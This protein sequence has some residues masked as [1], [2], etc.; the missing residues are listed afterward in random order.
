MVWSKAPE[1]VQ[2]ND[3]YAPY[4]QLDDMGKPPILAEVI[5]AE[6][7]LETSQRNLVVWAVS[8]EGLLMGNVPATYEDGK[9]KFTLGRKYASIYY[10]IQ[11]E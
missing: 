7:E 2:K 5:E 10:L 4:M 6:V 3:G 8:A 11:A 1:T 9:L